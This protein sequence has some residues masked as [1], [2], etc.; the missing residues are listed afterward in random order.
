MKG[1]LSRVR[2]LIFNEVKHSVGK[3]FYGL[4]NGGV[5]R[6]QEAFLMMAINMELKRVLE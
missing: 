3:C 4:R 5:Y 2:V 6:V 1:G